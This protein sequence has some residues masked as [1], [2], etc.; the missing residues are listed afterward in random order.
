MSQTATSTVTIK[1][2][3]PIPNRAAKSP[4]QY[5]THPHV[6]FE[7]RS[8]LAIYNMIVRDL[9]LAGCFQYC[10]VYV[11]R[12]DH[13]FVFA[14]CLYILSSRVN[15]VVPEKFKNIATRLTS[16]SQCAMKSAMSACGTCVFC[17]VY[18]KDKIPIGR[19]EPRVGSTSTAGRLFSSHR[20]SV[21]VRR[22]CRRP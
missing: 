19:R 9:D 11:L 18:C 15:I 3:R 2:E 12:C 8:P 17:S 6:P 7:R 10:S 16:N 22:G 20:R 13:L 4:Y 1:C 5:R 14:K 21:G